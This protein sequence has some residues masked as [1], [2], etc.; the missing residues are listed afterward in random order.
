VLS[1]VISVSNGPGLTPALPGA[2]N[3]ANEFAQWALAQGHT[4]RRFSDAKRRF[5]AIDIEKA[6]TPFLLK[7]K[8]IKTLFIYFAGHGE[9]FGWDQDYWILSNDTPG[10]G[11]VIDVAGTVELARRAGVPRVVV[12]A[13]ACRNIFGKVDFGLDKVASPILRNMRNDEVTVTVDRFLAAGPGT[14]ALEVQRRGQAALA[15]GIFTKELMK[16][17]RGEVP[18]IQERNSDND[19][20]IVAPGSLRLYLQNA[21]LDEAEALAKGFAQTPDC[22]PESDEPVAILGTIPNVKV[23]IDTVFPD[24]KPVKDCEIA[25]FTHKG[26]VKW[27]RRGV[28]TGSRAEFQ[29][30]AGLVCKTQVAKTGFEFK[31]IAP[32]PLFELSQDISGRFQVQK[33]PF[34]FT[35]TV[36]AGPANPRVAPRAVPRFGI[37]R[38]MDSAGRLHAKAPSAG[39]FRVVTDDPVTQAQAAEWQEFATREQPPR[40]V[41]TRVENATLAQIAQTA[42]KHG[43]AK[44]ETQTGLTVIGLPAGRTPK[45]AAEPNVL[46]GVFHEGQHWQI[47]G[48]RSGGVV[49]SLGHDQFAAVP[50]FKDLI[51]AL[52]IADGGGSPVVAD[53]SYAPAAN[54]RFEHDLI[55]LDNDPDL[56][57]GNA[58]DELDALQLIAAECARNGFFEVTIDE[59]IQL[60]ERMRRLKHQNP[61]FGVIAAYAY[62]QAGDK[63]Q[64]V[65]MIDWFIGK[66]QTVPFDLVMLAGY[67]MKQ[68]NAAAARRIQLGGD[69]VVLAELGT[70]VSPAWPMLTQGWA[71]L[72]A[73]YLKKFPILA[74]ARRSLAPGF[75]TTVVG[76]PGKD[77]FDY[78]G[79]GELNW[80]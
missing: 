53:L 13:D 66:W 35:E 79:T 61:V 55:A 51:G 63:A 16:A 17:L 44:F 30:P 15:Y 49:I 8:K 20:M 28:Q 39:V 70:W 52:R 58:R 59:S 3:G 43:R 19:R 37:T 36:S 14:A 25:L 54:S 34:K 29:L 22:R 1:V 24:G 27:D 18:E 5:T 48:K 23:V 4:V 64:I 21:V 9:C 65:D 50:I 7:K 69:Q 41:P 71:R 33:A 72:P 56:I 67:S 32:M 68:V 11:D 38:V 10:A 76:E 75:W 42:K 45:V 62:D 40:A 47:R 57:A 73:R 46:D 80:I 31:P 12:F 60:A 6:I 2:E 74:E 77:L 26:S 78:V